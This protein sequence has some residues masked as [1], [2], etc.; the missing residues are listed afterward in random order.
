[1]GTDCPCWDCA[2]LPVAWPISKRWLGSVLRTV[3]GY[4]YVE[5]VPIIWTPSRPR[6][7]W[8][9]STMQPFGTRSTGSVSSSGSDS[10]IA[11]VLGMFLGILAL[12]LT[13]S[14]AYL[15]K[16]NRTKVDAGFVL[17]G[18]SGQFARS[19]ITEALNWFRLQPAQ[20]V[21]AF[22][23]VMD[24]AA[25]PPIRETEEPEI[26]LVRDFRIDGI[27]WGRYEVWKRWDAD[28]DA[29]RLEWWEKMLARDISAL[30]Q[31]PT[32]SV[33]KVKCI[34]YVYR[35]VDPNKAFDRY[36]NQVLGSQILEAEFL[37]V[38]LTPSG[39]SALSVNDGGNLD[40]RAGARVSGGADGAAVTYPQASS[41]PI[42]DLSVVEMD[43]IQIMA[44]VP[45]YDDS[46][47]AVFGTNE[48]G[49]R[50]TADMVITDPADLP[51][52]IP[53]NAIIFSENTSMIL[54]S[55]SPLTGFG[56]L[57]HKGNLTLDVGSNSNFSGLL[58][59]DGDLRISAPAEISGA[60]IVTGRVRM[61]GASDYATLRYD[62]GVVSSLEQMF[63]RYRLSGPVRNAV[64]SE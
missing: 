62:S 30:R 5:S 64:P 13:V 26:G 55:D 33:W 18:Q 4:S 47:N 20:P 57:V 12:G 35:R 34:G 49:L 45:T 9:G 56:I 44:P 54:A 61:E 32:G 15:M 52:P 17:A 16:A 11:L 39:I 1:M 22:G 58:Y 41:T 14:G 48:M 60:V 28:P 43:G 21:L 3:R 37:R 63:G 23:P 51:S 2:V 42:V 8:R 31:M 6:G 29:Q 27:Y 24:T 46:L 59:V 7:E 25:S 38:G 50:A 10:G 19:G 40:L 36:P 53:S